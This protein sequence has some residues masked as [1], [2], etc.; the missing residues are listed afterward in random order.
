M[1]PTFYPIIIFTA[2]G[3]ILVIVALNNIKKQN[4]LPVKRYRAI[5]GYHTAGHKYIPGQF[6]GQMELDMRLP[7]RRFKQLYPSNTWTYEEYKKM[8]MQSAFRR[9]MS[10]QDNK[11]MVR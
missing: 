1:D 5:I 2:I 3:I 6:S 8:Q 9:S 10:S 4:Q 11:R 7:Y